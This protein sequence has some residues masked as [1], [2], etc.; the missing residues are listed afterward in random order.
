[1]YKVFV[2]SL[3]CLALASSLYGR[4]FDSAALSP[5]DTLEH[6]ELKEV[7]VIAPGVSEQ[8]INKP[9][10]SLEQYLEGQALWI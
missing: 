8:H 3:M 4:T 2:C 10:A 7:I 5:A 9:L 6:K 1:M